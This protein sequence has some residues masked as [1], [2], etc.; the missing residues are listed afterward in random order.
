MGIINWLD[1]HSGAIATISSV[2]T[3]TATVVLAIITRRY[4]RVTKHI[5]EENRLMRLEAHKPEIAISLHRQKTS[6]NYYAKLCVENIGA[7]PAHDVQ[8]LTDLSF[9]I[10]GR[11]PLEQIGFLKC[12]IPYFGHG[13]QLESYAFGVNLNQEPLEI[14]ATYRDSAEREYSRTFNLDFGELEGV[15]IFE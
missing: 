7:G 4:V 15:N 14:T 3:G 5:L 12:G 11:T 13:R 1:A 9:Q 8:F 10:D 2:I 6:S